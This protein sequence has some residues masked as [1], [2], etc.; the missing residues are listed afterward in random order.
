M[1]RTLLALAMM[2]MVPAVAGPQ[3]AEA[4]GGGIAAGS[5]G[6]RSVGGALTGPGY[7]PGY[8][9]GPGYAVTPGCYW[10]RQRFW[11]GVGWRSQNIRV[12]G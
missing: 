2:A 5:V 8:Y 7:Y 1:K 6:G 12:C 3:A 10:Q 9:G 4:R 11:D